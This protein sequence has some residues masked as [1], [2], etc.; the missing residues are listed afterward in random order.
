MTHDTQH[1]TD[2]VTS[3]NTDTDGT[4]Y[5]NHLFD[6][7]PTI[8]YYNQGEPLLH[9]SAVQSWAGSLE[10]FLGEYS[11]GRGL[12]VLHPNLDG[13]MSFARQS[14]TRTIAL[15]GYHEHEHDPHG[16][17]RREDDTQAVASEGAGTPQPTITGTVETE[18]ATER[19]VRSYKDV[20]M[21]MASMS[22]RPP[23]SCVMSRWCYTSPTF[24]T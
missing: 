20:S 15:P 7:L 16:K 22:K 6:Q 4:N 11:H 12:G 5:Y 23:E 19:L 1:S 3:P 21:V 2:G 17:D 14:S 9:A 24:T 8:N 13:A 18:R 10:R